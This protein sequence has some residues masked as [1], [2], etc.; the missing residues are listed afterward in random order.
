M[1]AKWWGGEQCRP[2]NG[3]SLGCYTENEGYGRLEESCGAPKTCVMCV[4]TMCC[5]CILSGGQEDDVVDGPCVQVHQLWRGVLHTWRLLHQT[6][7]IAT[8]V[9]NNDHKINEGT[10]LG[11][12]HS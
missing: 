10:A 5:S 9:H 4:L 6:G 7:K 12:R 1:L 2:Q 11:S 3:F 8:A